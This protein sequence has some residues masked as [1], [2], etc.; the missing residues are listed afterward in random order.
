MPLLHLP[1]HGV[2]AQLIREVGYEV[3]QISSDSPDITV[4]GGPALPSGATI[5]YFGQNA[6]TIVRPSAKVSDGRCE[7]GAC[8]GAAAEK[9]REV[10][11]AAGGNAQ[12]HR[13]VSLQAL[14]DLNLNGNGR[15]ER[16]RAFSCAARNTIVQKI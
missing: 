8:A 10:P 11:G 6:S 16:V 13:K 12:D 3:V 14:S 1:A 7:G 5:A 15:T 9:Q 4:L 2:P